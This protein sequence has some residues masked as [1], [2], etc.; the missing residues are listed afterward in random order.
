MLFK[1]LLAA[2]V[3]YGG[4]LYYVS[5][6]SCLRDSLFNGALSSSNAEE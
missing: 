4:W 1:V 5:T 3:G 2:G 6:C